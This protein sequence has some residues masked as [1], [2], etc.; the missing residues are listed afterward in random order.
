M[1]EDPV[2]NAPIRS[3]QLMLR[4]L[5]F[6]DEDI[7]AVIPDGIFGA[8]TGAAVSAFQ[9]K[10]GLPVTGIADA[11]THQAIVSA[12]DIAAPVHASPESPVT[13]FPAALRISPGQSHPH[14][15]LAQAM[16]AA[17]HPLLP[18]LAETG[19]TGRVD[20]PTE[21]NLR[22]LQSLHGSP[23]SG[24]LDRDTYNQLARLYRS[25][26]KRDLE[27]GCG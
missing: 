24:A 2:V 3:L 15:F 4:A 22:L 6:L 11:A 26:T 18:D 5:A 17:L 13:F 21:Q 8:S 20:A 14:I 16:M 12:Y 9:T 1:M 23:I 25:S 27:P 7:P 19:L 10:Y